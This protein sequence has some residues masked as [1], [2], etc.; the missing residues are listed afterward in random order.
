MFLLRAAAAPVILHKERVITAEKLFFLFSRKK[1]MCL[2][3]LTPR[4]ILTHYGGEKP[5]A[6]EGTQNRCD[7]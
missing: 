2:P 4:P 3:L 1:L 5:D 6:S 7:G